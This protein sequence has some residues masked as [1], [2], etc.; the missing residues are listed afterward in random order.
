[1]LIIYKYDLFMK[2]I[3]IQCLTIIFLLINNQIFSQK[4]LVVEKPGTINNIKYTIGSPIDIKTTDGIRLDGRIILITDTTVVIN[5]CMIKIKDIKN[6]YA[7]RRLIKDFSALGIT[8]GIAYVSIDAFNGLINNDTPILRKN[9]LK[10]SGVMLGTG[11]LLSLFDTKKLVIDNKD[12]RIK[13]LD[14]GIIN[15]PGVYKNVNKI[16]GN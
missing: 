15:D 1:M 2:T 11:L 9:A 3:I 16:E 4:L 12:W 10:I 7:S 13:I 8:G 6:I 14:F 5:Y